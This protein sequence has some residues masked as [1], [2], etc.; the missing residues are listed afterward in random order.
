WKPGSLLAPHGTGTATMPSVPHRI[1]GPLAV[2]GDVH[3]QTDKLRAIIRQLARL[4]DIHQRWIVFI[5]DLVDRGPDPAG[6]VQLY[7]D[8]T[9]QHDKVTWLCGNHE[10]AMACSLGLID[11]P[12]FVDFSERWLEHYDSHTTFQSYG[13]TH[14]DMDALKEALPAQHRQLLSDLPW[15]IEHRDYLFVHAGL[16]RNM[17]FETQVRILRERDYS[18]SHPPWLYSKEFIVQ[19][20]PGDCPVTVVVGH[21][22]LPRVYFGN[23]MIGTDTSGG[24]GGDLSCV[25]LPENIV[26]TSAETAPATPGS[27]P[28]GPEPPPRRRPWWRAW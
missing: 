8:L 24:T 13:V 1:D 5:G 3:G 7:C 22:P 12:D 16:D 21:V 26:L 19:G 11:T 25:L 9:T 4:P 6:T 18:L 27:P 2:I 17:P 15:G 23:G 28:P 10:L 20:P 14:R